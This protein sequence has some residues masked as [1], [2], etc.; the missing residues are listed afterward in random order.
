MRARIVTARQIQLERFSSEETKVF[1]NGE[2]NLSQIKKFCVLDQVS[3]QLLQQAEKSL[4]LSPRAV[5]RILKV[6]RT[7]ADLDNSKNIQEAHL[8]EAIQYR[9]D[10]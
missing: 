6:S 9:E 4:V 5:H 3:Y 8:A 1:T 2:M 7:I 10:K